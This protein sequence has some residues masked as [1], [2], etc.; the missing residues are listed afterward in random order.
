MAAVNTPFFSFEGKYRLLWHVGF[1]IVMFNLFIYLKMP[2]LGVSYLKAGVVAVKD[3]FVIGVIFYA[4]SYY[5]IP[6]V[7]LR[8]RFL[9]IPIS[10]IAIYYFYALNLYLEFLVMPKLIDLPG[11]GYV[12]YSARVLEAGVM[13]VFTFRNGAEILLDLSYLLAPALIIK[14]F[15][16]MSSLSTKT[17]KLE[18][19][20]I[21]LELNFLKSQINPHFLFNTLNNVYSLVLHKNDKAADAVLKLSDLMRYNLYD[22][23]TPQ[24][25]LVKEINFFRNYVELERMRHSSRAQIDLELEGDF[26]KFQVA[27]LIIFPFI[28]NAFK[29]GIDSSMSSAWV[30]MKLALEGNRLFVLVRNSK[31][32][33][34]KQKPGLVGGI[35]IAN[36]KKRLDLLYRDKHSLIINDEETSFSVHLEI[37]LK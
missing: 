35:G 19:D 28:E 27:P 30:K 10:V 24:I 9:L 25:D 14:L 6:Q 20:N 7:I 15:H 12:A 4:I 2:I 22:S 32:P 1:W 37:I 17:I 16:E 31:N 18:R 33:K 5:I 29:Y 26:E 8:K 34:R 23:N 13:G 36:S 11:R 21:N 3:V